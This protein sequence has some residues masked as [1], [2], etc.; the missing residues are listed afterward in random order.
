MLDVAEL[1]YAFGNIRK[2]FDSINALENW[3]A[4]QGFPARCPL[5]QNEASQEHVKK[6]TN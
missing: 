2:L 1:I 6:K 4:K 5:S 3:W